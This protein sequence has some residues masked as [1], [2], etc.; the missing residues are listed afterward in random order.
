MATQNADREKHNIFLYDKNRIN[1]TGITDVSEF[2]ENMIV[3]SVYDGSIITV[4]GSGLVISVLDLEK[5]CIEGQGQVS[6]LYY[7]DT[8]QRQKSNIFSLL[9]RGK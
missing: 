7:S 5:G 9:F 8:A 2:D 3:A 4:E 6:A 1:I